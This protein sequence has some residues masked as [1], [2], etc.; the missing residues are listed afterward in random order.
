MKTKNIF[1]MS[2]MTILLFSWGT[3]TGK[4]SNPVP[5]TSL[6]GKVTDKETKE[7]LPG[8]TIYIADLKTGTVTDANGNFHITNLPASKF[9]V[10]VSFVGYQ[11]LTQTVDLSKVNQINFQLS[12]SPIEVSE[13]VV[14]GSAVASD[15]KRTS[16]AISTINSNV[17]HT[18]P[19]SNLANSLVI[20][21]GVSAITTGGAVSKPVIRGLG[22]NHVITLVDGVRQEGNQWGDEHGLEIDQ[23]AVDRV[24]ILK[25]PASLL[26]GSDALG[27]VINLLE[28]VPVHAGHVDSEIS[29]D[30]STNSKLASGSVMN[31]GN[32][33][34]LVWKIRG[35]YRNAA[36]FRTPTEYVYNSAFNERDFS[37][38]FGFN[39]S[40]GYSHIHLSSYDAKIGAIDGAR[41]STTGKFVDQN[42]I[43]VPNSEL[44]TRTLHLPFQHV[45]HQKITWLNNFILRK[46][47]ELKINLGYQTNN[48]QEFSTSTTT[49]GLYFHLQTMTYDIKYQLARTNG[50]APAAGI[51][52]MVQQNTNRGTEFL[53]PDYQLHD[54][55]GFFYLK[56]SLEKFT[57]NGGLRY[58]TRAISIHQLTLAN[59]SLPVFKGFSTNLG[60]FSGAL[61]MT[62]NI[63]RSFDMKAN[64][65]RGYRAPNIAELSSNG[66]HEGTFRYEVGNSA[67]KPETST[68]LD[69]ELSFHSRQ[70]SI[71]L[72]GFYNLINNYIYQRNTI[73]DVHEVNGVNYPV[74]RYVQG[75]SL[76]TGFELSADIHPRD[77]IHFENGV[78]YVYGVN[79]ETSRPL[80]FIPAAHSKHTLRWVFK[81]NKILKAPYIEGGVDFFLAQD[82]YDSFET[83]TAGY[84]LF[85]AGIGSDL[86]INKTKATLFIK[87]VNLTNRKYYDHLNRLKYL[88]IY[89]PG[90]DITFGL[91]LPLEWAVK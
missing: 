91:I 79:K 21:P 86:L 53:I 47:D 3:L 77:N 62:W 20:I 9:M 2:L 36:S 34:G 4:A 28:P 39:K 14:T 27:G 65:G 71:I 82:R 15:I 89:N 63:N 18:I 22:Y 75:N 35:T 41:D 45:S 37:G 72:S 32:L 59:D 30:Y 52:G 38:M 60:A 26:Y 83:R 76:L 74:Y 66:L 31:Q 17:L 51:S 44:D 29:S 23:Y 87:C 7:T 8:A 78:S 54:L 85:N 46:N 25:G 48:R 49:P 50:W 42:G 11:T 64:L 1:H 33:N 19:S 84:T 73:G 40:W 57:F 80:P 67:L 43:I 70:S 69:G 5:E 90:R 6:I 61:G 12:S 13:V 16:V 68:Q 81:G 88:N 58:D 10:Q 24:E 56:K 55:G